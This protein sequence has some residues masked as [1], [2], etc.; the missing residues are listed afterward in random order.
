MKFRQMLTILLVGCAAVVAEAPAY[1]ASDADNHAKVVR[2]TVRP[3]DTL[4]SIALEFGVDFND[5]RAWNNLTG[6]DVPVGSEIIVRGPTKAAPKPS[7][8]MPVVHVV[9][10]GD[11]FEGIAKKYKVT[12]DKVRQ[13]NRRINPRKLQIGQQVQL[14]LPGRGGKSESYGRANGGRLY[15]G[16]LLEN[17]PGLRVRSA[18]RAYAT[19]RTI[20]LLQAAMADVKARWPDA[21]ELVAGDLSQ[22]NGGRIRPHLSHQSGRDADISY[23]FRGNVQLPNLH[24][25]TYETVDTVKTWHLFKTLID[26]GQV[27]F[28]FA[29]RPVQRAL[30]E[31]ARSIGYSEE[32]LAPILQYPRPNGTRAGIIRHVSG[33]DTHFHIR[34]TCGPDDR[35]CH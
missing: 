22:R 23:Y 32:E 20:Q 3:E 8:P 18:A 27:E 14:Y 28:I 24:A 10:R 5:V 31:Y 7:G 34:F 25:M 13:W 1:A 26:T 17:S 29:V 33:H 11:T 12:L 21:P 30:Y 16:V 19:Q 4:G 15:N 9:K 2:Y 35:Q 6:L